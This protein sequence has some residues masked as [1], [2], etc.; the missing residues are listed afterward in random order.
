LARASRAEAIN[1]GANFFSPRVTAVTAARGGNIYFDFVIKSADAFRS[2]G[3]VGGKTATHYRK[4]Q[5]GHLMLREN[6]EIMSLIG[7]LGRV[8]RGAQHAEGMKPAQWEALRFLARANRY[9]RNPGA[10]AE[11]LS[12]T[13][14]TVSQT[15]IALERKGYIV[16][17]SNPGDGRGKH[18]E[19]T[20]SGRAVVRRD[21]LTKLGTAV[22]LLDDGSSVARGLETI[23]HRMVRRNG[24]R[25]FGTCR[26]CGHFDAN[27]AADHPAG[28]NRCMLTGE[29]LDRDEESQICREHEIR[30]A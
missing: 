4:Q 15:L 17:M 11:F 8:A 26:E 16:R 10:L 1:I 9:S 22:S 3:A 23:L 21:P 6:A 24:N 29:P 27:A 20:E 18:L 5:E 30:V 2:D 7:R 13:R 12:S 14:G 25:A 19:L 28:P